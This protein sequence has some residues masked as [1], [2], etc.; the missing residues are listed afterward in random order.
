[1][2]E[3]L[4]LGALI[5]YILSAILGYFD[6]KNGKYWWYKVKLIEDDKDE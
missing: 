6:I 3:W 4:M 1:M 5:G 2:I